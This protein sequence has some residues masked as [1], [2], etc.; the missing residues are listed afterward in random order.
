MRQQNG[1]MGSNLVGEDFL[2]LNFEPDLEAEDR[3]LPNFYIFI[4]FYGVQVIFHMV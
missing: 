3:C 2:D 1:Q 4:L